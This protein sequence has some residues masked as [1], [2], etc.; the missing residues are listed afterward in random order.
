M[1]CKPKSVACFTRMQCENL[2]QFLSSHTLASPLS[3]VSL[4]CGVKPLQSWNNYNLYT[5]VKTE[6]LY[7]WQSSLDVGRK[8]LSAPDPLAGKQRLQPDFYLWSQITKQHRLRW[9]TCYRWDCTQHMANCWGR[10]CENTVSVWCTARGTS[11]YDVS[12]KNDVTESKVEEEICVRVDVHATRFSLH[13]RFAT[14]LSLILW[15]N[16]RFNCTD[17]TFQ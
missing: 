5:V 8:E 15:T 6:G 10:R 14:F 9:F 11:E 7:I 12:R 4:I 17:K 1:L 3:R 2:I 16:W 13:S